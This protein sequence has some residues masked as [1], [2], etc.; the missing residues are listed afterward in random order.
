MP[1]AEVLDFARLVS[2]LADGQPTGSDLRADPSPTSLY[3]A[4][5]DARSAA[6]AAERQALLDGE[7]APRAEWRPVLDHGREALAEKT[8]DLEVV[9]YLIEALAREHGFAGLRDG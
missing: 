3:Y 7:A 4:I 5:K 6:R 2:P 8:K 9:A 1:S